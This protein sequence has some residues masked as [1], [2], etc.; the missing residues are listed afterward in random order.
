MIAARDSRHDGL[1]GPAAK[2]LATART[3]LEDCLPAGTAILLEGDPG[4]GKTVVCDLL[5]TEVAAGTE[6]A[7]EHVNGQS[8]GV[9]LVRAWRQVGAYGN[10]FSAFTVKRIDELDQASPAAVS[11][12]LTF[13][14]YL[15]AR[16]VVLATTNEYGKLVAM[17]KGRLDSRFVRLR[18][19]APSVDQTVR[20]LERHYSIP[21]DAAREIALG[22]V[23][24]GC[25]AVV[26][27]NVRAAIKDTLGYRAACR[28]A[29]SR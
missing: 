20:L 4:V 2:V 17:G 12:L 15:P 16:T 7:V 3:L 18:V 26:G 27:C 5:A 29:K 6:I 25:L 23:P 24:P 28:T 9:D 8:V 1:I 11:E 22:A 13:L 19:E 10:L 14:D 21:A